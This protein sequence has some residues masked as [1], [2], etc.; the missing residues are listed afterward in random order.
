MKEYFLKTKRIGFSCWEQEDVQLAI[1]LWGEPEVA[2]FICAEGN[3]TIPEIR[4]RLNCEISNHRVYG[5]QYFPIFELD[6][7]QLIGCCGLR[8]YKEEKNIFEIGFHLKKKYQ[9][10]GLAFEAAA[11]IIEYAFSVLNAQEL[12]AGHHP[13]NIAF[14]KLLEKLG[15]HYESDEYYAP[16]GLEHPTYYLKK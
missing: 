2:H 8:P 7:G 15:F 5:I 9:K 3:F 16:T 6:S 1:E 12:K 4:E 14:K 11:A 10:Q 13:Q